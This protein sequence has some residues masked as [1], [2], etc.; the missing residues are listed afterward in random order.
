MEHLI[1]EV[2]SAARSVA[3]EWPNIA[4]AEDIEQDI[5]VKLL[6]WRGYLERVTEMGSTECRGALRR[7]GHQIAAQQRADYNVFSG[8]FRYGAKEVRNML[9]GTLESQRDGRTET[10]TIDLVEAMAVLAEKN[11]R[12]WE[13]IRS[14]VYEGSPT[15]K[16]ERDRLR[17]AIRRLTECMNNAH[18]RRHFGYEGPGIRTAMSNRAAQASITKEWQGDLLEGRR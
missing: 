9:D 4:V 13:S 10:E 12:Y 8:N 7:I 15:V 6:E 14:Y 18:K 17:R 3:I 1:E 16:P 11:P 2:K 5:W